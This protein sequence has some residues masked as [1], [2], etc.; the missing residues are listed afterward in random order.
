MAKVIAF[1]R[2]CPDRQRD[3][4]GSRDAVAAV[5]SGDYDL[6]DQF[7]QR[8]WFLGYRVEPIEPPCPD[9]AS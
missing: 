2:I 1:P 8:L 7:L 4:C 3:P 9:R 6:A 5:C